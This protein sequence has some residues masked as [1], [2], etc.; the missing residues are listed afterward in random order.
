MFCKV[1]TN[2]E[3]WDRVR[4]WTTREPCSPSMAIGFP[5]IPALP[6]AF[7]G[8]PPLGDMPGTG[9]LL[10]AVGDPLVLAFRGRHEGPMGVSPYRDQAS[11]RTSVA[12]P[13]PTEPPAG[14]PSR[15]HRPNGL[16][17]PGGRRRSERVGRARHRGTGP[18]S[19]TNRG[20]SR[21]PPA[22][23]RRAA[24]A[25]SNRARRPS[26]P[27]THPDAERLDPTASY[28]F[29]IGP[30]P[31]ASSP[32]FRRPRQGRRRGQI[33]FAHPRWGFFEAL[34]LALPPRPQSLTRRYPSY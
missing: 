19:S 26:R 8:R 5:S 30:S 28:G 27:W 17:Y 12:V 3:T 22:L 16:V 14:H 18:S 25:R 29:L 33:F 6:P 21:A 31:T 9:F 24:R 20:F 34:R 1:C 23:C 13:P 7:S 15:P 10:P 11:L 2:R 4:V 32:G